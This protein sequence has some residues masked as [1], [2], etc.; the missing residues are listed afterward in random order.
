MSLI[1]KMLVVLVISLLIAFIAKTQ[2][3]TTTVKAGQ[4]SISD[5]FTRATV[6]GQKNAGGF[7]SIQNEGVKDKL[8]S[9]TSSASSVVEIHEMKMDG[10]VMQMRQIKSLDIPSK[11]KVDLKPG[12]YHL[13]FIDLK[14]P[15]KAG[16]NIDV[17]LTF[18]K[19]GKVSVKLPIQEMRP[20][21]GGGPGQGHGPAHRTK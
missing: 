1:Q 12:G 20:M 15:L 10:N 2:A 4:L 17:Q 8:L 16:E 5:T 14:S 11:G 7:L 3:Q 19:A 21:H 9:A 18:E 13:M 6:A